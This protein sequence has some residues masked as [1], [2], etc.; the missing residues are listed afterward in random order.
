VR[1]LEADIRAWAKQWNENPTPFTW[2]KTAEEISSSATP[3]RRD[4]GR[5]AGARSPGRLEAVVFPEVIVEFPLIMRGAGIAAG[6]F[7]CLVRSR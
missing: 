2:T 5:T 6:E 7:G 4:H 1:S 3:S